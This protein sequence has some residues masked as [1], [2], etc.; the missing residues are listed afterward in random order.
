MTHLTKIL[1]EVI[2]FATLDRR[3]DKPLSFYQRKVFYVATLECLVY[4][5]VSGGKEYVQLPE[6]NRG[7]HC[8]CPERG[9]QISAG[10]CGYA[11]RDKRTIQKW[12]RARSRIALED[13]LDVFDTLHLPVGPYEIW[14]L[15]PELFP[16]G[17]EDIKGFST[18]KKRRTLAD[19]YLHQAE[20]LEISRSIIPVDDH[21]NNSC[22]IGRSCWPTCRLRSVTANGS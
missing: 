12:E 6:P 3:R 11:G 21:R 7:S 1:R 18:E 17:M 22:G 2:E 14:I 4:K 20:P 16:R 13:F 19:Y 5:C 8:L 9:G 15:H 10:A